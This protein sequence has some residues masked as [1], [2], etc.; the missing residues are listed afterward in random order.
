[1][2]AKRKRR[3]VGEP[4]RTRHQAM[5]SLRQQAIEGARRV[6]VCQ[7]IVIGRLLRVES[8][9]DTCRVLALF[10]SQARTANALLVEHGGEAVEIPD[11]W[12][13]VRAAV[14]ALGTVVQAAATASKRIDR[15]HY[16]D[17]VRVLTATSS[18]EPAPGPAPKEA[19]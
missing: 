1:M 9:Q 16:A 13:Q 5:T 14:K 11:P 6:E 18:P 8:L 19:A 10:E 7:G 2:V 17:E 15:S 12:P 3:R 4:P